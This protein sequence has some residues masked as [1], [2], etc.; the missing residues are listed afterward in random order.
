MKLPVLTKKFWIVATTVGIVGLL[1]AYYLL[2]YVANQR[3]DLIDLNYRILKRIGKNVTETRN[4]FDATIE[5]YKGLSV[6]KQNTKV[7]GKTEQHELTK[8]ESKRK[9]KN[10]L[11]DQISLRVVNA[12]SIYFDSVNIN[13]DELGTVVIPVRRYLGQSFSYTR[14]SFDDFFVIRIPRK[15]KTEKGQSEKRQG[16]YKL[17]S[18]DT[19]VG[20][21]TCSNGIDVKKIDA[22]FTTDRGIV[23]IPMSDI[24]LAGIPYKVFSYYIRFS[25]EESWVLCGA[26]KE[27]SFRRKIYE[28]D[29][30]RIVFAVLILLFILLAMP[31]LKL[32]VMNSME[33]LRIVN[34]WFTGFSIVIGTSIVVLMLISGNHLLGNKEAVD[35]KLKNL[36]NSIKYNFL[37]EMDLL[38]CQLVSIKG[39]FGKDTSSIDTVWKNTIW[40]KY[41][42]YPF[43]HQLM[44]LDK[45]GDQLLSLSPNAVRKLN[46]STRKYFTNAR[47]NNL[48]TLRDGSYARD[49]SLESVRSYRDGKNIGGLSIR[50]GKENDPTI[51]IA[52]TSK[53]RSIMD[54]LLPAGYGFCII[55]AKGDVWFH[56]DRRHN[57]QENFFE[58]T[59]E[60]DRIIAADTGRMAISMQVVYNRNLHHIYIQPI[61]NLP[62][63]L[64][65]FYDLE[66]CKSP[67]ILTT[68]YAFTLMLFMFSLGAL[69][70]FI[71]FIIVYKP[72]KLKIKR[73]YLSW[74]RPRRVGDDQS[75]NERQDRVEK[76]IRS[77]T[78]LFILNLLLVV[79]LF[80]D[81]PVEAAFSFLV[82]PLYVFVF[83]YLLFERSGLTPKEVVLNIVCHSLLIAL[84]NVMFFSYIEHYAIVVF[85]QLLLVGIL[86]G[87]YFNKALIRFI[88]GRMAVKH[89]Y[90]LYFVMLFLW[91][92]MISVLPVTG[93]YRLAHYEESAAWTK[94]IQ[95]Q[96]ALNN[97]KR[98][99]DIAKEKYG[100]PDSLF[101]AINKLGDYLLATGDFKLPDKH[102]SET[103]PSESSL[104][105]YELQF[106][107]RPPLWGALESS[108]A[109]LQAAAADTVWRWNENTKGSLTMR[110]TTPKGEPRYYTASLPV[111]NIATSKYFLFFLVLF[112][113]FLLVVVFV[114]VFSVRSIF[115]IAI[116]Q[117]ARLRQLC[118][119]KPGVLTLLKHKQVFVVGLPYSGKKM[120]LEYFA[121]Y[122]NRQAGIQT[123]FV[124]MRTSKKEDLKAPDKS[125]TV[126]ILN[127]EHG[128]NDHEINKR[129][130]EF[131]QELVAKD[132]RV[133]ISSA[134]H[135]N[136][137]IEFCERILQRISMDEDKDKKEE[138]DKKSEYKQALRMWKNALSGFTIYFR[139]LAE[140]ESAWNSKDTFARGEL[141]HGLYLPS[142]Q[143]AVSLDNT[144]NRYE[145]EENY[146]L[147][148]EEMA[149]MYYH[150]LWNS[151]SKEE[152]FLLFDL[153]KDR[154]VNLKNLKVIRSLLRKGIIV[155]D[156]SL[157][158][159]NKSFNNF[160]LSVVKEDEEIKMEDELSRKGSWNIVQSVL[161]IL[162]LA[163]I[164]FLA[165]AK[166]DVFKDVSIFVGALAAALPLL[167]KFGGLFSSSKGKDA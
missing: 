115:G 151:F 154:F 145:D 73:F 44:G 131:I 101:T 57:L 91:L 21:Q 16:T 56:S 35:G 76:Y 31:V 79:L 49:F 137:V 150:S 112:I 34:V 80:V 19:V 119:S 153:A 105:R 59:G 46:L 41:L 14:S 128:I 114:V 102:L 11:R 95:W 104:H 94:Y 18:I 9:F 51:A 135:P 152:K 25:D 48:W 17:P 22:L 125:K 146:I 2:I 140:S 134:I 55:D 65:T 136:A 43:T 45:R 68:S 28:V 155:A 72:T 32:A 129:K 139:S 93:F 110:F 78:V 82:L 130:L 111:F 84:M 109:M 148:V 38:H 40:N 3:S 53:L 13:V 70:L 108:R 15:R 141:N 5:R 88:S 47:D 26:I 126:I 96:A 118:L 160:I 133:I 159:M 127:F 74:L 33:R 98:N 75:E 167:T 144:G 161:L 37:D 42:C 90:D 66:Y 54:P 63:R 120:L 64:V 10:L 121:N 107:M 30:F 77:V 99:A 61:D 52:I 71:Q 87:G 12:S 117:D 23:S 85:I 164:T 89:S 8:A 97:E 92:M 113:L 24:Q 81:Y 39:K 166:Q 36:S 29:T 143:Y 147:K 124:D 4:Y 69:Q 162:L 7:N 103:T 163:L 1:F 142:L 149:D 20:F 156:D 60:D 83:Q 132:M 106:L 158:I 157:Q 27:T 100:A 138:G 62:L 122:A 86:A 116:I 50:L 6:A 165:L 123:S 67:L 58:E